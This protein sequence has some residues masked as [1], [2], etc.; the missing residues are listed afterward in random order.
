MIILLKK[1][2][3]VTF[4]HWLHINDHYDVDYEYRPGM[5]GTVTT[6]RALVL[7]YAYHFPLRF[8]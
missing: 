2:K 6:T 4:F 8:S 5:I 3:K 1:K 7:S